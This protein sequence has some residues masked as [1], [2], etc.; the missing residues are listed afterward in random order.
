MIIADTNN[1]SILQIHTLLSLQVVSPAVHL[2][3]HSL[4]CFLDDIVYF[5]CSYFRLFHLG[6]MTSYHPLKLDQ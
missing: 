5:E 2:L 4:S 1:T 6:C 3:L